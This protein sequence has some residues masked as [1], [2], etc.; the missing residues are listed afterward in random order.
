MFAFVAGGSNNSPTIL[1]LY[2]YTEADPIILK[3]PLPIQEDA[4]YSNENLAAADNDRFF[5][6][7]DQKIYLFDLSDLS[8]VEIA[9]LTDRQLG[10]LSYENGYLYLQGSSYD[11]L[12]ANSFVFKIDPQ[13]G[14]ILDSFS[15]EVALPY[16]GVLYSYLASQWKNDCST[17]EFYAL[18]NK[19]VFFPQ[20][21][22]ERSFV[23]WPI[24]GNST[25]LNSF[26]PLAQDYSGFTSIYS[27]E[28]HRQNCGLRLDLDDDDS[29]GRAGPHYRRSVRCEQPLQLMDSDASIWSV[30]DSAVDSVSIQFGL[31]ESGTFEHPDNPAIEVI[32]QLN[33]IILRSS[34]DE[35]THAGWIAYLQEIRLTLADYSI[36]RVAEVET[37]LYAGGNSSDGA[38]S[39]YNIIAE[40]Y[41]AGPDQDIEECRPFRLGTRELIGSATR[42]GYWSPEIELP[43]IHVST[44]YV[45]DSFIPGT[46]LY[47]VQPE[48]CARAD[49]A[50]ITYRPYTQIA[51]TNPSAY[52]TVTLCEGM[53]Y[54]WRPLDLPHVNYANYLGEFSPA[55][56]RILY[57]EGTYWVILYYNFINDAG[58]QVLCSESNSLTIIHSPEENVSRQIDTLICAGET[59]QIGGLTFTQP[60]TYTFSVPGTGCDTSYSLTVAVRDGPATA[61]LD[62]TFCL[63]DTLFTGGNSY[64]QPGSYSI[65]SGPAG[66][67]LATTINLSERE[68]VIVELDT[69]ICPESSVL[70]GGSAFNSPGIYNINNTI[71][72]GCD[73]IFRLYLS[74]SPRDT[75]FSSFIIESG[76]SVYIAPVDTLLRTSGIYTFLIPVPGECSRLLHLTLSV[77][78]GTANPR[79]LSPRVSVTNPIRLLSDFRVFDPFGGEII[80]TGLELFDLQGRRIGRWAGRGELPAERLPGGIYLYRLW[81]PDGE[82]MVSGKLLV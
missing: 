57:D 46:Y 6:T 48:G 5:L 75:L 70:Y 17:K 62:T 34:G 19:A 79:T 8:F 82:R 29:Q 58:I 73:T 76:D 47:I 63:G 27:W 4:Y 69:T 61:A 38:R 28:T 77:I 30:D 44:P 11:D 2:E 21:A 32:Q 31:G 55:E 53:G 39:Y 59:L 43:Y 15:L 42:G 25:D 13:A 3:Y 72:L 23:N 81:L 18:Q 68:V 54:E 65:I 20:Q 50:E 71:G 24:E 1:Y 66:C 40:P 35:L 9:D 56:P 16:Q 26:C 60:A 52:D 36:S 41:T 22:F 74:N 37:I 80:W 78:T 45:Q 67:P 49:T 7:L 51:A 10:N 33:G 14:T 12:S 64:T